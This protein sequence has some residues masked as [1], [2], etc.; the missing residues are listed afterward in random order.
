MEI[1]FSGKTDIGMTRKRNEDYIGQ[2]ETLNGSLFIVCDG[3]GGHAGGNVASKLA[4]ETIIEVFNRDEVADIP[5]LI[6][7]A[8]ETANKAIISNTKTAPE[9][10]GMG[11]TVV[12][13]LI[14][15]TDVFYGNMGD[16]RL[17]FFDGLELRRLT[18][19][20]SFVQQLLDKGIISE[21]EA[22]IHP[23]K[24]EITQ[25]LGIGETIEPGISKGSFKIQRGDIFMLCTDGLYGMLSDKEIYNVLTSTAFT[26][27]QK[28]DI[29]TEKANSSGGTDNISV[30]L[31]EVLKANPN[32]AIEAVISKKTDV[33]KA[34]NIRKV[35]AI[36][37]LLV[38][39]IAGSILFYKVITSKKPEGYIEGVTE[40]TVLNPQ[41]AV[42]KN[43]TDSLNSIKE[44][45]VNSK[46][47]DFKEI[48]NSGN[49]IK[50]NGPGK[51]Q[52]QKPAVTVHKK[53][54]IVKRANN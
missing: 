38:I 23:R 1:I 46:P 32:S 16:S 33:K 20:H 22:E 2:A 7:T 3:M 10:E 34:L 39:I 24:N 18:K 21:L 8:F 49:S 52:P 45:Q 4:V 5:S 40:D 14:K 15:N 51:P 30:H 42:K 44:K 43:R 37:L 48:G 6:F 12:L 9:L 53:D 27:N 28:C 36:I 41:D 19:D 11:T 35:I 54:S 31:I 17:Y 13:L 25:A 50:P 47:N 26:L 29:L